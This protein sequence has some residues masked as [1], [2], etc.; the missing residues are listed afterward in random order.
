MGKYTTLSTAINDLTNKGYTYNFNMKEDFIE[1]PEKH[2]QLKPEEFEIDEKY[3]FQ[4]M[5]DVDNESVLYAISS[6]DGKVRGLLVNAYGIY[7]DYASFKLVQKL[8]RP[9]R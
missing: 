5:S 9:G 7:A 6:T 2:C 4:E 8:N 1:C 3:R